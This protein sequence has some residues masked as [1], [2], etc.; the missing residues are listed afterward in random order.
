VTGL[1]LVAA[2]L[3][4]A[5]RRAEFGGD[6]DLDEGGRRAAES[7][8]PTFARTQTWA[9]G[10]SRAAQQTAAALGGTP[11]IAAAL[12]D[13]DYGDWTGHT[14][15]QVDLT[16][17]LTDPDFTPPGGESLTT[18]RNRAGAWLD[19]HAGHTLVAVAHTTVVRAALA[20]ALDL[21]PD[22][23][24]RLDVAPLATLPLTHRAGRWHLHLKPPAP[25][26]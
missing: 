5:Q 24:W 26:R 15:D 14:L 3:T 2:A 11:T 9:A 22:G 8:A 1:L 20:H 6:Q 10:P 7:L 12:A 25:T 13:A 19:A 16:P 18:V 4:P 23:I 17:W 21:P